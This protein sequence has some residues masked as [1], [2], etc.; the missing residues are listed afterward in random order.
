MSTEPDFAEVIRLAID[1]RLLDLHVSLPCRVEAYDS[2]N[3][4][5]DVL[6][7]VRRAIT[8]SQGNT[9]HEELPILPNV[10]VVF[11]RAASFSATWPLAK[12]DYVL[13]VFSSSAIGNW[14]ESGDLA[15]PGDLR[16]H[17]L[18]YGFAI[19][20]IAPDGETIPTASDAAV[21]EVNNPATHMKVGASASDWVAMNQK[22]LSELSAI[23]TALSS[24]T[25]TGTGCQ[26]A[27]SNSTY[28][29]PSDVAS[30]KLKSE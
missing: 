2:T 8:D 17:D 23:A 28:T 22:V 21:F 13:V 4:T 5:V 11:P 1:S 29:A 10:P 16:R 9:Q 3:Q 12:G 19:P 27:A 7:M 18:S 14:R 25:H 15:D 26:G 24:H 20:G 30:T 6:P